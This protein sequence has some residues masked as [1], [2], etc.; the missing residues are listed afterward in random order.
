MA[1]IG[2]TRAQ[3]RAARNAVGLSQRKLA[4]EAA[5]SLPVVQEFEGKAGRIPM[6][7]NLR[8]IKEALARA[9]VEFQKFPDGRVAVI[10]SDNDTEQ[11]SV[12][13]EEAGGK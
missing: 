1:K 3:C 6:E 11:A 7:K 13:P 10:F 12:A 4:E 8:D 5:V 9:G 2:L